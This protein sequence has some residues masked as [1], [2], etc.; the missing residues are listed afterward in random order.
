[1][2]LDTTLAKYSIGMKIFSFNRSRC[3]RLA[4]SV[5]MG[6]II[7][8]SGCKPVTTKD[9]S[10][11]YIRSSGGVLDKLV[12]NENG[13]FQQTISFTNGDQWSK[14][15]SWLFERE[16][17]KFDGFLSAF[18]VHP[19]EHRAFAVIPPKALFDQILWVEKGV[20]LKDS[21]QPIWVKQR[22]PKQ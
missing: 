18:D 8:F 16:I 15:G 13:I 4:T 3:P 10:G 7:L 11:V 20:L 22:T 12:L 17:V 5:C 14:N 9:I 19:F 2:D 1:M 21:E 6:L